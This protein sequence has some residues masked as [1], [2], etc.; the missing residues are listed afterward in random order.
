MKIIIIGAGIAAVSAVKAI[1][2]HSKDIEITVYGDEEY[3][4]YKRIRLTKDLSYGLQ[5][6]NL[7]IQK[8]SWYQ[9]NHVRFHKGTRVTGLDPA[10]RRIFLSDGTADEYSS[11][12]L[13]NGARNNVLPIKG[14]DKKG[15]YS[16]RRLEDAFD[17]LEQAKRSHRI[18]II[19]G[20]VLGLE[21]AWSLKQLQKEVVVVEALPRL[22]PK[23]LDEP[24][25][26]V[27]QDIVYSCGVAV[28]TGTQ[29]MEITG[30]D[31]VTGF[32]TDSNLK[33][34]CDMVI[35]STG[36]RSNIELVKDTGIRTHRGI[37][38]NERMETNLPDIYA[39]GDIAEY[40]DRVAGLWNVASLQGEVAGSNM[41]GF[42]RIY[43]VPAAA[44]VM[45]AFHYSM[46]SIGQVEE[47][48]YD[49]TITEAIAERNIYRKIC[50]RDNRITGAAMIG[51][52]RELP[53]LKRAM[54]E[55]T[56]I[57]ESYERNMTVSEFLLLLKEKQAKKQ[58]LQPSDA[59][60]EL[61]HIQ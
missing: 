13:A 45:N 27:L 31:S 19:G 33:E 6:E 38:V 34:H 40:Q 4:P 59:A 56:E 51:S 10:V 47:K 41:A 14:I 36:I 44:T 3:F 5:P 18:L 7:L 22:M 2:Q 26:K 12:L 9:E 16:L 21:I 57:S 8:E 30:D 50:F 11:L 32:I 28:H 23:Q 35:H 1:R 61:P 15:V 20:G 17:I 46:F 37:L 52:S 48:S 39:A 24:A 54:E 42:A 43:E 25:S 49:A 55:Q 58:L 53:A 60:A 29:T